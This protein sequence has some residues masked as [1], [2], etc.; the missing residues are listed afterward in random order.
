LEQAA[1]IKISLHEGAAGEGHTLSGHSRVQSMGG[2]VEHSA[3]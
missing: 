1:R 3:G 2:L